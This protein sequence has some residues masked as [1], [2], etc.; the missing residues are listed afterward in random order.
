MRQHEA[1]MLTTEFLP[2]EKEED[3]HPL[4]TL[5]ETVRL[6]IIDTDKIS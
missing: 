2:N 5:L 4:R 6:E 1:D 3:K